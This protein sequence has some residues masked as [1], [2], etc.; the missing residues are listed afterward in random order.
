MPIL[1]AFILSICIA[2]GRALFFLHT[3]LYFLVL[4]I[5]CIYLY[6][7]VYR[8]DVNLLIFIIKILEK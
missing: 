1:T 3:Y 2:E 6:V 7:L 8:Q 4:D 5:S